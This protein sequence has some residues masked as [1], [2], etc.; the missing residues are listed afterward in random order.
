MYDPWKPFDHPLGDMLKTHRASEVALSQAREVQRALDPLCGMLDSLREAER[1]HRELFRMVDASTYASD[2]WRMQRESMTALDEQGEQRRMLQR[3]I[4]DSARWESLL[5][6]LWDR[7]AFT[8]AQ[9][10]FG[11][12]P[13]ATWSSNLADVTR[14]LNTAGLPTS[15]PN[16]TQR[17]L[18]PF[19]AFGH[20]SRTVVADVIRD[21]SAGSSTSAS[22]L[23]LAEAELTDASDILTDVISAGVGD[24]AQLGIAGVTLF[25]VQAVELAG[26]SSVI[27]PVPISELILL[28]PGAALA[29]KARRVARLVVA[30]NRAAVYHGRA[31]LVRPTTMVMESLADLSWIVV[32]DHDSFARFID[33][34]YFILYEGAGTARLRYHDYLD[35]SAILPIAAI[36]NLRNKLFRHD[37]DQGSA[38][39]NTYSWR[40]LRESMVAIG[41]TRLPTSSAEYRSAQERLLDLVSVFLDQL[42]DAV[43][44]APAQ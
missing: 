32:N 13:Y 24:D 44:A 28:S 20:F 34:L 33:H 41:I 6:P 43:R 35:A 4:D 10:A 11:L 2:F 39:A 38:V 40:E 17:L 23:R 9:R 42:L 14:A 1:Q 18:A 29:A 26:T 8:D 19:D 7:A 36:K 12:D 16:L 15:H 5:T 37:G 21:A 31:E 30:C 3:V 27:H 22:A 25:D